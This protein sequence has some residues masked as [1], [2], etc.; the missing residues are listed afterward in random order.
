MSMLFWLSNKKWHNLT[1]TKQINL[2]CGISKSREEKELVFEE[3]SW[4][5]IKLTLSLPGI[6]EYW[7]QYGVG[8]FFQVT[9]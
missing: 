4:V 1:G 8:I 6:A 7:M 5:H 9:E 2:G 3:T